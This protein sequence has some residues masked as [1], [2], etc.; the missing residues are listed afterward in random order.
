MA[1]IDLRARDTWVGKAACKG[2][3]DLFF[4]ENGKYFL[5]IVEQTCKSC[6]VLEP[7]QEWA[8]YHESVGFQGGLTPQQRETV[9]KRLRIQLN[10]PN[11]YIRGNA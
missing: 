9:R 11:I 7:C 5:P 10:E 6:P 2:M 1:K 4:P 8:V 3:T